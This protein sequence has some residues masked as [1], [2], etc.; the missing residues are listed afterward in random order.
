[1]TVSRFQGDT[2]WQQD[3]R[4]WIEVTQECR[5]HAIAGRQ[6]FAEGAFEAARE[7]LALAD[8]DHYLAEC[9]EYELR[10]LESGRS[11]TE[12][13]PARDGWLSGGRP[14]K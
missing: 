10:H 13:Q 5:E 12:S 9:L 14:V 4:R 7:E 2:Q 3:F 1:M 11:P 6:L 8:E